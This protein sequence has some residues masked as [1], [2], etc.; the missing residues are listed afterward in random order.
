[1]E[2]NGRQQPRPAAPAPAEPAPSGWRRRLHPSWMTH[3]V[4]LLLFARV[5]MSTTRALAGILVPIYLALIGFSAV[6][7]GQL[8]VVV[9]LTS[10]VLSSLIGL[11]S[12]RIGRKPFLIALPMLTALSGFA[13]AF[14]QQI[15]LL[16]VFAAL[17]SFGRGS[18]AGA[19]AVGPY[20]PAE[21]ALLADAVPAR[22][23]NSMFG[24]VAFASSLGAL[25]GGGPFAAV[26]TLLSHFGWFG[27][28][29]ASAYRPAFAII[30]VSSMVA[31]LLAVPITETHHPQPRPRTEPRRR[32]RLRLHPRISRESWHV[33]QRLWMTNSVNGLAIGFFGPFITY[34]FYRRYGVGPGTIGLL[35][36]T[37]NLATMVSNLGAAHVA[38]RLGLVRAIIVSRLLQAALLVPMVLAPTFWLAGGVYLI[39]MLAQR[40]ALPLRQSYVM[41]IIPSEERGTVGA[42]SNLPSQATSAISPGIAGYLFAHG[43]LALPFEVGAVL[44]AV[45]AT[46]YFVFFRN[47]RPPEERVAPPPRPVAAPRAG[48]AANGRAPGQAPL[49]GEAGAEVSSAGRE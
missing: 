6:R 31:G 26:P 17:G 13:F 49:P 11:L 27:L 2:H 47:I 33:L 36:S 21:Q 41:A 12:D 43:S 48:E 24:V 37:I 7:L 29:G 3:D 34:W 10:A 22:S 5:F 1:M 40:I 46:M 30:G 19:G 23:R 38:G 44:Q 32:P 4:R 35:Y 8:F 25:I 20:Q 28:H 39:R 42:L 14:T 45:N 9:A 18:G 16:F 15:P